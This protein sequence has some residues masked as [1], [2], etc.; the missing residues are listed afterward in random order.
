MANPAS[1]TINELTGNSALSQPAAQTLDTAGTVPINCKSETDRLIIEAVNGD[2][3]AATL[4]IKAGTGVQAHTAK[5]LAVA[6]AASGGGATA[7]RIIG[8]FEASRFVKADGSIDVTLAGGASP[9]VAVRV[10]RLPRQI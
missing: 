5:D 9:S 6:L 3:A 2:D 8:P 10:Y 1:L 4:T 7:N